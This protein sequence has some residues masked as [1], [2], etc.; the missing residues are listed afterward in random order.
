V[1]K[2]IR[3]V[4]G[5]VVAL[6]SGL[7]FGAAVSPT[8]V[9]AA[10]VTSWNPNVFCEGNLVTIPFILGAAYPAQSLSGSL[11]QTG[12]STGGVPHPRALIPPCTITNVDGLTMGTF[13]QI[14][15]VYLRQYVHQDSDCSNEFAAVNG[16]G[17][18]PDGQTICDRQG[19]ILEMGTTDGFLEIEVEKDWLAKGYCGPGVWYCESEV[20]ADFVSDGSVSIDVQGFVFWD[21]ENW[22]LHPFT[23]WR[24]TPQPD[25]W[26]EAS[27]TSLRIALGHSDTSTLTLW[28]L[29]GFEGTVGLSV[30]IAAVN[31]P[32]LLP[33]IYPDA[34]VDPDWVWLS[35]G[36]SASSTL[37]VSASLLT[38]PGT[39]SVTVTATSGAITRSVTVS[40][41]IVLI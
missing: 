5:L 18:Y 39:Y 25:I 23:A 29:H 31:V 10:T 32:P 15:R 36:G 38:T 34:W 2:G 7:A 40:V 21:G 14:D 22:E 41:E 3:F 9:S 11:Y 37:H 27:P 17:P 30:S 12:D 20:L 24:P 16:G 26:M 28:S 33:T 6:L 4:V 8:A 35:S 13:V 19:V 1:V